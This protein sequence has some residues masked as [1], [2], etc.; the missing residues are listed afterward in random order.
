MSAADLQKA[1]NDAIQIVESALAA[2]PGANVVTIAVQDAQSIKDLIA[3]LIL[4]VPP[5][6]PTSLDPGD[7]EQIDEEITKEEAKS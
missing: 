6:Y 4:A 3:Q 5:I 2:A 7:R 1:G